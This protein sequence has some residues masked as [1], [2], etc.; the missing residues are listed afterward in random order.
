MVFQPF[1]LRVI[2]WSVPTAETRR[3]PSWN[4]SWHWERRSKNL[5]GRISHGE[6][7]KGYQQLVMGYQQVKSL[8]LMG[9][10]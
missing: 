10:H 9:Y 5:G 2:G 3:A 4:D 1:F 6:I 7:I 8:V